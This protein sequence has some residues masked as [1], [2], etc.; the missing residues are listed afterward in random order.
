MRT[1]LEHLP[2]NGLR[3]NYEEWEFCRVLEGVCELTPDGGEA[4]RFAAGDSFVIEP[5]LAGAW[6]VIAP[7]RF[8]ARVR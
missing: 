7:K 3:V 6:R 5:R 2:A 4:Q 1:T 8:V